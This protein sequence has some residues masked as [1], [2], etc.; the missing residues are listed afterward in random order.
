MKIQFNNGLIF[1]WFLI[2]F[3]SCN[4]YSQGCKELPT[5][6]SSYSEAVKKVKNADFL[7]KESINTSKSS[8]IRGLSYYSCDGKNGFL[9]MKTDKKE[10]IHE[11]VPFQIW[12]DL[13]KASSF[14][15]SY[16]EKVRYIY[17]LVPN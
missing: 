1:C 15:S 3:Y 13:K 4:L 6:F 10:Y 17:R 11:N 14:G 8:W 5:N 16:N 12:T 9:I 7:I 2:S